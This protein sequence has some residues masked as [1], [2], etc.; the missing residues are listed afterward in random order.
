M[1]KFEMLYFRNERRYGTGNLKKDIFLSHLQPPL[2]TNSEDLAISSSEFDDVTVS[3]VGFRRRSS[4]GYVP[5][6]NFNI[7][8]TSFPGNEVDIS[9]PLD[10]IST[11]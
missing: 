2:E 1:R 9:N 3:R 8:Q 7:S 5:S 4:G 11:I 10:S 6:L